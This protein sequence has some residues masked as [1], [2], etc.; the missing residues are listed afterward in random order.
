L[1]PGDKSL[2][3]IDEAGESMKIGNR[4]RIIGV[5]IAL[6]ILFVVSASVPGQ[7][8]KA[9]VT[10]FALGDQV[11]T[12]PAPDG[13]EEAM[14]QFESIKNRFTLTEAPENDTLAAHLLRADCEK[15]RKGDS[16]SFNFYTKISVRKAIRTV[17]FSA[18]RFADLISEFR[19]NGSQVLDINSPTMKATL[20]HLSKGLTE[21]N[22]EK[23]EVDLSQPVNLGEF[24]TRP[25][26]YS[27]MLL[28]NFK[29]QSGKDQVSVP[30]VGGLSYVR[31]KQR[32]IYVYTYRKYES[33]TD[34]NV[35]RDFTKQWIGQILAAN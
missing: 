16:G 23:T 32:L 8:R 35:L 10:T 26:V 17:D 28:M 4:T 34:V 24:D 22:K 14:S 20:E 33:E 31:L 2:D 6:T 9:D 12:I 19:K 27:V 13:F 29:T 25:N 1:A 11:I 18:E 21:L 15:L 30:I 3:V 7:M 5:A